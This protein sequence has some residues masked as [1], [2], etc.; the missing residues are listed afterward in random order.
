MV[1]PNGLEGGLGDP[2]AEEDGVLLAAVPFV[3]R[4]KDSLRLGWQANVG[5]FADAELLQPVVALVLAQALAT[6]TVPVFME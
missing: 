2:L 6:M 4:G 3:C 5:G 1:R